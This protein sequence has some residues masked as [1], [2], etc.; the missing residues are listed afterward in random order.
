MTFIETSISVGV[1]LFL[2]LMAISVYQKQKFTDTLKELIELLKEVAKK[3][4]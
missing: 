3:D 4:G 2:I 1:I